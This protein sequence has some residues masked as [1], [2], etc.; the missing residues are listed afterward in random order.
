M[1]DKENETNS[2]NGNSSTCP[3]IEIGMHQN[4]YQPK[5]I[6]KR[7]NNENE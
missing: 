5:N 1:K 3:P 2:E 4:S 7:G 6:E